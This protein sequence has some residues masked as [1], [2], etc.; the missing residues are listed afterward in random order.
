MIISTCEEAAKIDVANNFE[1][2]NSTDPSVCFGKDEVTKTDFDSV[3]SQLTFRS[4]IMSQDPADPKGFEE[5][6]SSSTYFT[7]RLQTF[8]IE[9]FGQIY[10]VSAIQ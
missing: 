3:A 6:M 1:S 2:Y 4:K 5:N 9:N 7:S 10:R 8:G